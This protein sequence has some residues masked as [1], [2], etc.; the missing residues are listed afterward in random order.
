MEIGESLDDH[1]RKIENWAKKSKIQIPVIT[2]TPYDYSRESTWLNRTITD[3]R[4][5]MTCETNS[6]VA[7]SGSNKIPVIMSN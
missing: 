5:S 7:F 3:A 6:S 1:N 4:F 2:A